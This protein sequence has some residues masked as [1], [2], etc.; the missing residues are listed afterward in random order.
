MLKK[1]ALTVLLTMPLVANS[2]VFNTWTSNELGSPNYNLTISEQATDGIFDFNLIIDPWNAEALG[3]FIDFGDKTIDFGSL[4]L[5]SVSPVGEV[6]IFDTDTSSNSCGSGCNLSGLNPALLTP[7]G[8]W[9]L[10]FSLGSQ[11]FDNI[12]EFSFTLAGLAGLNEDDLGVIGLR[13]QSYCDEGGL[14]PDGS[15]EGSDKS[16]FAN[17]GSTSSS[18]SSTGGGFSSGAGSSGG[19]VPEPSSYALLGL[20]LVAFGFHQRKRKVTLAA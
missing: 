17:T 4:L 18:T 2:A 14:L 16:Y 12:Q 15:C 13:A 3:M 9:E 20:G 5:S 19:T 11:G 8:E 6:D 7:D 1:L 10:V